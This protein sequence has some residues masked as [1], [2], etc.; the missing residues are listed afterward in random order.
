MVIMSVR[1][2]GPRSVGIM[3]CLAPL[4]SQRPKTISTKNPRIRGASTLALFHG[5]WRVF[6]SYIYPVNVCYAMVLTMP[7]LSL[8]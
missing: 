5:Y 2:A 6:V 3:G 4:N 7:N 1:G 8:T